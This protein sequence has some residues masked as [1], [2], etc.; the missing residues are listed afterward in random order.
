MNKMPIPPP[1][2]RTKENVLNCE[3]SDAIVH[4]EH[5]PLQ[6]LPL[7]AFPLHKRQ[8]EEPARS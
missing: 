2:I 6:E 3:Q 4:T 7:T 1:I 8:N 5:S